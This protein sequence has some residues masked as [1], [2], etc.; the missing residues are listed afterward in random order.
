ML[1]IVELISNAL[2]IVKEAFSFQSKKLDLKNASDVKAAA[3]KQDEVS[4]KDKTAKAI[5]TNDIDELRKEGA[6]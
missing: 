6:E 2:G 4:A 3:T 5:A 1:G